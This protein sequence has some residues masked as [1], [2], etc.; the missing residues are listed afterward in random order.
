MDGYMKN[1]RPAAGGL[2]TRG[3]MA[4]SIAIAALLAGAGVCQAEVPDVKFLFPAG[5][6]QGQTQTL[7]INGKPGTAPLQFWT[8]DERLSAAAGEKE[9][10]IAVTAAADAP[11]GLYWLRVANAEGASEL[12]PLVV[13]VLPEVTEAGL[14]GKDGPQTPTLPTTISGVLTRS[15]EVDS[16]TIELQQDQTLI[17]SIDSR[18]LL[19][20]PADVVLQLTDERG[21]VLE[22]NDDHRD[23]DPQ[24]VYKAS[25]AGKYIVRVFAFPADPNST[26]RFAG[27]DS[28]VYRLTLTTGPFVDHLM[29]LAAQSGTE[30]TLQFAGWNLPQEESPLTVTAADGEPIGVAVPH[31]GSFLVNRLQAS[32]V[33]V[34]VEPP[35]NAESEPTALPVPGAASGHIDAPRQSDS[36]RFTARKDQT[37]VFRVR[38]QEF[39]SPLDSLLRIENAD[40]KLLKEEDD[41]RRAIADPRVEVKFP[42]DAEYVLRI[43]D[44]F[45]HGGMRYFYL[46]QIDEQRPQYRLSL[47]AT[48]YTVPEGKPLEIPVTVD[49]QYGFG[50]AISV[51]IKGL[52]AGVTAAPVESAPK[53]DSSKSVTL[54]LESDGKSPFSGPVRIIGTSGEMPAVRAVAETPV[55][56]LGI[57]NVW[58]TVIGKA[59]P[60]AEPESKDDAD[61]KP[62]PAE[63]PQ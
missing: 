23:F 28:Y 5:V 20:S 32:S 16:Y 4:T 22:Q 9:N 2:I 60:K 19:A 63:T 46:L 36:F 44:R 24:I 51:Q 8:S 21:F 15:G 3:V 35:P 18:R 47:K 34:V 7:K 39:D 11:A 38:A 45:G 14:T 50:E 25:A 42:A 30:T 6:Q 57:D 10:Q 53:G 29:P 33:P 48:R 27:G 40:G 13:G 55:G 31:A 1:S 54:K 37:L 41:Q 58:L 49:R 62:E 52:P 56:G 26:I 59:E 12:L 43:T 61:A 17:A